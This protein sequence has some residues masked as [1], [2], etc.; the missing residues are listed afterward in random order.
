MSVP[1][2]RRAP[3]RKTILSLLPIFIWLFV[4]S[5]STAPANADSPTVAKD[6]PTTKTASPRTAALTSEVQSRL[7]PLVEYMLGMSPN[8]E[9]LDYNNDQKVDVAD[10]VH[11]FKLFLRVQ[12]FAPFAGETYAVG[13]EIAV[14]WQLLPEA[15][16]TVRMEIW[17][18][19]QMAALLRDVVSDPTGGETTLLATPDVPQADDYY[20]R[21]TS[22]LLEQQNDPF[23][24][25]ETGLFTILHLDP[26][27]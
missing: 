11:A 7:V 20:V 22:I 1:S 21:V 18:A 27:P 4:V 9:G 17:R 16:T 13:F 23:P 8:V 6:Q 19:G 25:A 26:A 2:T 10:L 5:L 12:V 14:Q 15:G 24:Y 3:D